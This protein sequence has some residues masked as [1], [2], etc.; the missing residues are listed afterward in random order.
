MHVLTA[1]SVSVAS[2]AFAAPASARSAT[3]SS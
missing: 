1:L 3:A 2:L